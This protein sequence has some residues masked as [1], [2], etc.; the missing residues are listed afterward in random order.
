[1]GVG[2]MEGKLSWRMT[3]SFGPAE[4]RRRIKEET[5]LEKASKQTNK[6]NKRKETNKQTNK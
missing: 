6:T 4:G 1:M 3:G 5:E 2:A